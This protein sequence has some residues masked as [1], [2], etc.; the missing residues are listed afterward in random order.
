MYFLDSAGISD[1][2]INSINNR[3]LF[4]IP[5]FCFLIVCEIVESNV[6]I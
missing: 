2:L 6:N 5:K 3:L 4:I 1:R